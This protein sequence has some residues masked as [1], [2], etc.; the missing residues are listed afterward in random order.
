MTQDRIY[1]LALDAH[2]AGWSADRFAEAMCFRADAD[3]VAEVMVG[4]W[5]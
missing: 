1:N 5:A 2:A 4:V 3:L